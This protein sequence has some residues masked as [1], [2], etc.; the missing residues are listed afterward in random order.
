MNMVTQEILQHL[1]KGDA[2]CLTSDVI[3]NINQIVLNVITK[4]PL[5]GIEVEL[6]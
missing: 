2:S 5:T 3:Y 1:Y 6:S 4:E